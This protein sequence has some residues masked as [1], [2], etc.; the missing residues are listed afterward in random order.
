M[1]KEYLI[2]YKKKLSQLSEEEKKLRDLEL[3]NIVT[4]EKLGPIIE[5]PTVSRTWVQSYDMDKY[6]SEKRYET[7]TEALFRQNIDN[8][9]TTAL[10]YFFAK[11]SYK[12]FFENLKKLVKSFT[13]YGVKKGDYVSICLA[14]IPEA[15]YSIYALGYIGAVGIFL[16]PYLDKETLT[17]DIKKNNSN[18][19]LIMD[20]FYDQYKEKF[21]E[22]IDECNINNLVMVPTLNSSPLG[23]IKKNKKTYDN[24]INYNSFIKNGQKEKLVDMVK[25]EKDMPLAVV[26]S[27]GTTGVLKGVLLSHDA[28]NNSASSYKSFGFNLSKGQKVYQAIPVWSSTG[29]IADGA[30]ALYYGCTLHQDPRFD[31]V[32]YS[33]NL[34][35][36][37]DNW[38]VATTELFNGL[39]DLKNDKKFK[40][41]VK[42]HIYDYSKLENIYIGGTFSTPK[43]RSRLNNVLKELGCK[44]KVNASYG[45]CEN[46]SIVTAE[47]N[48][49]NYPDYSVGMPI[50]GASIM[51]VDNECN[52]LPFN[53][54]GE[55][56]VNTDCGMLGYYNRSDLNNI[57]FKADDGKIYK[58]TGDIGYITRDGVLIYEGRANDYSVINDK[59]I[60]NFD[61]KKS[62]L[63]NN[64]VFDCEVF[65][66]ND[67]KLYVNIIFYDRYNINIEQKIREI[68][69]ELFNHFNDKDYVPEYFKIRDSFP[70]ASSTKRNYKAIKE[71]TDGYIHLSY[72]SYS[73]SLKN[74]HTN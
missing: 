39:I 28:F 22:A 9:S 18:I 52:E 8:M 66:L 74:N 49:R 59:K 14:G 51:I 41:F 72:N 56:T 31:P 58:H 68:Q 44:F 50:P 10:E 55:I 30:T 42:S 20:K 32:T 48:N 54:R 53:Q 11:I 21:D 47:L 40:F 67:N 23:K 69:N 34:G 6:L 57:F 13:K 2:E 62:I 60:F 27:S 25:Y 12:E 64:D 65:S 1:N 38:G 24:F 43:D 16:A 29:L 45:T 33:K 15:M 35:I 36:H 4:G 71:E 73:L 5:Y 37:R 63:S 19:L 61:I 46:G 7:V 70:M 26:Y 3:R 17:K